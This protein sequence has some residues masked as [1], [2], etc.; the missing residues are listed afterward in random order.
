MTIKNLFF[1]SSDSSTTINTAV[2]TNSELR[3]RFFLVIVWTLAFDP[4]CDAQA[5]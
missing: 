2:H 3:E 1:V 4:N 5:S